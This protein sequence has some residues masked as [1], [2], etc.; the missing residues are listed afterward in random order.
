MHGYATKILTSGDTFTSLAISVGF[1][2]LGTKNGVIYILN[3]KG[4]SV[5]TIRA[6]TSKVNC[7]DVDSKGDYL[8]SGG[9]D[10]KVVIIPLKGGADQTQLTHS[11]PI[12]AVAIDPLYA[13]SKDN[14]LFSGGIKGK[15][16]QNKKSWI[17]QKDKI[18]Q[19]GEG[20]IQC[21]CYKGYYLAWVCEKGIRIY[22]VTKD[23]KIGSFEADSNND[24]NEYR[25]H[26]Y[27]ESINS[28]VVG[29]YKTI[30]IIGIKERAS[31][32]GAP[33]QLYAEV[34][35]TF[36]LYDEA[37]IILGI[38]PF[39]Y[40]NITVLVQPFTEDNKRDKPELRVISKITNEEIAADSLPIR[41]Y[42]KQNR[43]IDYHL[44]YNE[45]INMNNY[46][47]EYDTIT[48]E[49][50]TPNYYILGPQDIIVAVRRQLIDHIQF[51]VDIKDY[52]N[53]LH[54]AEQYPEKIDPTEAEKLKESYLNHIIQS[55][56]YE[57][58]ASMCPKLLTT[59]ELWEKWII[60]F[61][62]ASKLPIITP[63][64]PTVKPL[65]PRAFYELILDYYLKN[66]VV[67]FLR[68]L[69][70]WPKPPPGNPEKALYDVK[71]LIKKVEE[72]LKD[73]KSA[74]LMESAAELY[75]MNVEYEKALRVYLD[76][77]CKG[78]DPVN[79]FR[80]IEEHK[81]FGAVQD[82]I[83]N[84]ILLDSRHAIDM[85]VKYMNQIPVY[86]II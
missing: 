8:V 24:I 37:S 84:L 21:I 70:T 65:L 55:K 46:T 5:K 66:D 63:Y 59:P 62:Q 51:S 20:A 10:G 76:T 23:I 30:K 77:G 22:D 28:L 4:E 31:I 47:I 1:I 44:C 53:A 56:E 49:E 85:L 79:V 12:Y 29:W 86:I 40:Q 75:S 16:T 26:M 57:K 68:L 25:A 72:R 14:I 60:V 6:H 32:A 58:A 69:R 41:G 36:K 54:L 42:E 7:L 83:K 39:D 34:T 52:E 35:L 27:W 81:L 13:T 9:D 80:L 73:W 82:K 50:N 3:E 78:L 43:N 67:G 2:Y 19:Q 71:E 61:S 11:S 15:I 45:C 64:V 33:P 38:A 48:C 74:T 18:I 17:G